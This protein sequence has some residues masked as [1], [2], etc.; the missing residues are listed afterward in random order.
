[1]VFRE[2]EWGQRIGNNSSLTLPGFWGDVHST[3]PVSGA[4]SSW[5]SYGQGIFID[6]PCLCIWEVKS[7]Q[8]SGW[9]IRRSLGL[10]GELAEHIQHSTFWEALGDEVGLW[11]P[12]GYEIHVE[13]SGTF[14]CRE[15]DTEGN[16][17]FCLEESIGFRSESILTREIPPSLSSGGAHF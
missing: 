8:V 9:E 15:K 5:P 2:R 4:L 12:L 11:M 1:M 16:H 7:G 3:L 14:W 6:S 10:P 13:L 17:S